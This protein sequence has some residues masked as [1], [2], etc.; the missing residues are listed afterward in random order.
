MTSQGIIALVTF[1]KP[2]VDDQATKHVLDR[3]TV[4]LT[5]VPENSHQHTTWTKPS[6]RASSRNNM[7]SRN[8]M[9][10]CGHVHSYPRLQEWE[11]FLLHRKAR[12][13]KLH[14][15]KNRN[16]TFTSARGKGPGPVRS[17]YTSSPTRSCTTASKQFV[18]LHTMQLLILMLT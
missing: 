17:K 3:T 2:Y 11:V 10:T 13:R 8:L 9:E 18:F 5:S 1:S 15:L 16:I 6:E 14:N 7:K 12:T 4:T